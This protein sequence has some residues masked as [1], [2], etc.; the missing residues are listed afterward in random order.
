MQAIIKKGFSESEDEAIAIGDTLLHKGIIVHVKYDRKK[1]RKKFFPTHQL[2]R[3][4]EHSAA[5]VMC[6][7][8]FM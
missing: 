1:F 4:V 7:S 5:E 2:Y 3:W 8:S 6:F